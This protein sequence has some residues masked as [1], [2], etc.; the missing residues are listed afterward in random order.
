LRI[1]NLV[2]SAATV[3]GVSMLLPPPPRPLLPL[4]ILIWLSLSSC[5]HAARSSYESLYSGSGHVIQTDNGNP[6][7]SVSG[8]FVVAMRRSYFNVAGG[9]MPCIASLPLL[10]QLVSSRV[11]A[12]GCAACTGRGTSQDMCGSLCATGVDGVTRFF[13]LCFAFC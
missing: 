12:L 6:P 9:L 3:P 7:Y 10:L 4:F 1:I 11:A 8:R 13:F 2:H 5:S